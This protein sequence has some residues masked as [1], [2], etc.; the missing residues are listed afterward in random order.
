MKILKKISVFVLV[1]ALCAVFVCGCSVKNAKTPETG[2]AGES[3]T[4]TLEDG[5]LTVEGT[6]SIENRITPAGKVNSIVVSDGI[7]EI[8][9]ELFKDLDSVLSVELPDSLIKIGNGAF[10]GMVNVKEITIPDSVSDVSIDAFDGWKETQKII[11]DWYSGT[12]DEWQSFFDLWDTYFG[13]VKDF[14]ND[15]NLEQNIRSLFNSGVEYLR[16]NIGELLK[17][18]GLDAMLE[19]EEFDVSAMIDEFAAMEDELVQEIMAAVPEIKA[20]LGNI[21]KQGKGIFYMIS[22]ELSKEIDDFTSVFGN[23]DIN[24]ILG[25]DADDLAEMFSDT[26]PSYENIFK[27]IF[28]SE[29]DMSDFI[30]MFGGMIDFPVDE[31]FGEDQAEG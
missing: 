17:A 18:F 19:E 13:Y 21:E 24:S 27:N 28:G 16:T 9:D 26:L 1:A 8:G 4:W 12:A 20:E 3:A 15:P 10:S 29:Q 2:I 5:V 23:F 7:T 6:G 22:E 14:F 25:A 30:G 31:F 11:T